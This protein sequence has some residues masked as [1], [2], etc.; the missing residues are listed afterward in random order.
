M[1]AAVLS[2][3]RDDRNILHV[4]PAEAADRAT[5]GSLGRFL[6]AGSQGF[7]EN[8]RAVIRYNPGT[9]CRDRFCTAPFSPRILTDLQEVAEDVRAEL[10]VLHLGVELEPEQG[11]LP[12][13][14][15]LNAA[16]R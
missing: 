7:F 15:R 4:V 6:M 1:R 13:P 3:L 14:H 5:E 16:V 8:S 2:D 9:T 12:V 11:S 10:G